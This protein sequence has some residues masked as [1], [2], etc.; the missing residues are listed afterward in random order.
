LTA[1]DSD[2]IKSDDEDR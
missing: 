1:A 2:K